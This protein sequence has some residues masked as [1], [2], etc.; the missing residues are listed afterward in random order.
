VLYLALRHSEN[1]STLLLHL[2]ALTVVLG[3]ALTVRLLAMLLPD[4]G[5]GAPAPDA[6]ARSL[7]RVG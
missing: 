6:A 3:G 2:G 7:G 5:F 4:G 1:P